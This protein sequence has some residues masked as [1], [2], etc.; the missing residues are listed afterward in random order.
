MGRVYSWKI[1][2]GNNTYYSWIDEEGGG[3][4]TNCGDINPC[5][6]SFARSADEE[7]YAAAFESMLGNLCPGVDRSIFRSYKAYYDIG[8]DKPEDWEKC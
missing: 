1:V 8:C 7:T 6:L 2:C 4:S 5:A 3:C